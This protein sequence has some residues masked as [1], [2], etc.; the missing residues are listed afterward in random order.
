V[1]SVQYPALQDQQSGGLISD[2]FHL[3]MSPAWKQPSDFSH[4]VDFVLKFRYLLLRLLEN[5]PGNF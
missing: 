5:F 2:C 3:S 4:P 1:H